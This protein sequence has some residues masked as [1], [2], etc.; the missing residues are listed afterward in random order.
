[1]HILTHTLVALAAVASSM[2]AP[3]LVGTLIKGPSVIP[4]AFQNLG[5]A[6]DLTPFDMTFHLNGANLA[7]LA[8][9]MDKNAA[10]LAGPLTMD[11][12]ASY[13]TPSAADLTAVQNFLTSNGFSANQITYSAFKDEITVPTTVGKGESRLSRFSRLHY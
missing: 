13:A 12:V 3:G 4:S 8:A 10:S 7:G 2:A 5:S 11:Q 9:L 6:L 1:M